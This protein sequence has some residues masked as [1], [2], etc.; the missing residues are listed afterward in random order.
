MSYVRSALELRLADLKAKKAARQGAPGFAENVAEV[1][2]AI[3]EIE[4][5][6]QRTKPEVANGAAE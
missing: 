1:D 6:L 5:E 3:A 2:A 4:A